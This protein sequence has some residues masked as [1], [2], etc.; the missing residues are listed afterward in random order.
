MSS[1]A[2]SPAGYRDAIRRGDRRAIARTITL[3]E[4]TRPDQAALTRRRSIASR[5]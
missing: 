2:E 4:S 3:L 5:R 1:D